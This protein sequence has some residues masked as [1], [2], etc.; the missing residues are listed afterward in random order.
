MSLFADFC[1]I[2][3]KKEKRLD[4]QNVGSDTTQT[5]NNTIK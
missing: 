3:Q 1:P 2:D 4:L 5:G